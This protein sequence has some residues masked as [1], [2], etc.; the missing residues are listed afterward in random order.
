MHLTSG[1]RSRKIVTVNETDERPYPGALMRLVLLTAIALLV[2]AP[3]AQAQ[4][5]ET[6]PEPKPA[7]LDI[8]F[9][10]P[11]VAL[12]DKLFIFDE[13]GH[14]TA[15]RTVEHKNMR[16]LHV[17]VMANYQL[18]EGAERVRVDSDEIKLV[19][20][21]G[22]KYASVGSIGL[23]RIFNQYGG[24]F[25][26][27]P[28]RNRQNELVDRVFAIPTEAKGPFTM[29]IAELASINVQ[30]PKKSSEQP[31]PAGL[32][33]VKVNSIAWGESVP[34]D[35]FRIGDTHIPTTFTDPGRKLL[36]VSLNVIAKGYNNAN[37]EDLNWS[38]RAVSIRDNRGQVIRTHGTYFSNTLSTNVHKTT[39][40][41]QKDGTAETFFFSAPDDI[42]SFEVLWYGRPVGKHTVK[43]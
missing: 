25:S 33:E 5:A 16:F 29:E 40:V 26:I 34:G 7:D 38:S 15:G 2:T 31:H 42:K 6:E 32:V 11:K 43:K 9:S 20:A 8:K 1:P 4:P 24:S 17:Q 18:P 36:A 19:T 39:D 30:R 10:L 22:K 21:D 37:G 41:G 28:R 23:D 35:E 13:D 3:L 12:Y 14:P 27:Y